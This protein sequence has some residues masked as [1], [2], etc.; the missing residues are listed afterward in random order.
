M[1]WELQIASVDSPIHEFKL[2]TI[3]PLAITIKS[4]HAADCN[5][6]EAMRIGWDTFASID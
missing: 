2:H 3:H 6:Q 4:Y 1:H 5:I